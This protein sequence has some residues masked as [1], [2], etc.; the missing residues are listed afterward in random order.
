MV[1]KTIRPENRPRAN[2]LSSGLLREKER[3]VRARDKV[4]EIQKKKEVQR[5]QTLDKLKQKER[6]QKKRETRNWARRVK[7]TR[8][9]NKEKQEIDRTP[10]KQCSG[11]E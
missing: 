6:K 9:Q 7:E 5:L 10:E 2:R 3:E 4:R 11:T 8:L 1:I